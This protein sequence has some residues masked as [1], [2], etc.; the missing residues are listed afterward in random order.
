MNAPAPSNQFMF[1]QLNEKIDVLESLAKISYARIYLKQAG[2]AT[3][4]NWANT[5]KAII[6]QEN[7]KGRKPK[8]A[9]PLDKLDEIKCRLMLIGKHYYQIFSLEKSSHKDLLTKLANYV[10]PSSV[11]TKNPLSLVPQASL[12]TTDR[13]VL[14]KIHDDGHG[15]AL[16]FCTPRAKTE[17]I[18]AGVYDKNGN[19]QSGIMYKEVKHQKFDVI[20]IP[21]SRARV[22]IRLCEDIGKLKLESSLE[23]LQEAL[24]EVLRHLAFPI[25]KLKI[26]NVHKSIE[27]LYNDSRFGIMTDTSFLSEDNKN[28]LPRGGK[29]DTTTCIRKQPYHVEGAKKE[30]VRCVG[31]HLRWDTEIKAISTSLTTR[32]QM[33]SA[34]H[35]RYLE[36]NYFTIETPLNNQTVLEY[37]DKILSVNK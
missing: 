7:G 13:P 30:K 10:I 25:N 29:V 23:A 34:Q 22:E 36:C 5:R 8:I 14:S 3:G 4:V 16:I 11:Y 37:I 27:N 19:P 28:L 12:T 33:L 2:F 31:I 9:A 6:E 32:L 21:K 15:L 1:A 18:A 35:L 17:R 20:Y 24:F 26:V